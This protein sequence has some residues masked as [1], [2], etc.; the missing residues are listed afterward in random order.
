M[1]VIISTIARFHAFSLAKT[2]I[3]ITQLLRRLDP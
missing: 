3:E 1:K 2:Y